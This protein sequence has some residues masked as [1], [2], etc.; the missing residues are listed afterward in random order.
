MAMS[1]IL[2]RQM[3]DSITHQQQHGVKVF[4]CYFSGVSIFRY[5]TAL[6]LHD[7]M[8]LILWRWSLTPELN[9]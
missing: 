7:A 4:P 9:C 2:V 8:N 5:T 1:R 6:M 3:R